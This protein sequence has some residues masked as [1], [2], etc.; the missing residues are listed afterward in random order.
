[1]TRE[2]PRLA[3][4]LLALVLSAAPGRAQV[5][6]DRYPAGSAGRDSCYQTEYRRSR[7]DFERAYREQERIDATSRRREREEERLDRGSER[8]GDSGGYRFNRRDDEGD[9]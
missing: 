1:M 9:R 4:A 5:D 3:F 8:Q 2:M 6:C 7:Q